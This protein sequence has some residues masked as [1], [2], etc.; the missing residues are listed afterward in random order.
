MRMFIQLL[1]VLL[2]SGACSSSLKEI[3]YLSSNATF[4][5]NYAK[6]TDYNLKRGDNV[7]VQ[8]IGNNPMVA[9]SYNVGVNNLYSQESIN[10]FSH[11]IDREG[12]ISLPLIGDMKIVDMTIDEAKYLISSRAKELYRTPSV[13]VKL[14][15]KG[16][17]VL[18]EVNR[19]GKYLIYKDNLN[20]FEALGLAGDLSDYANRKNIKLIREVNGKE[21]IISIDITNSNIINDECFVI[22]PNDVLY[23]P[24]RNRVYGTKTL[25]YTGI[26]GTSLSIVSTI[27][28][29]VL[30]IQ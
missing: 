7:Y 5:V 22:F 27:I 16:V 23:A 3:Q 29:V 6:D 19:P 9:N 12:K 30:L 15:N 26:L 20:V 8:V 4:S 11:T 18:G 25:S 13:I 1:I 2:V 10:L 21:K 17:T 28:S 24:P 14:V